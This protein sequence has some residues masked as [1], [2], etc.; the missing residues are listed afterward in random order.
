M[1]FGAVGDLVWRFGGQKCGS[2][3][4]RLDIHAVTCYLYAELPWNT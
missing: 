1:L 3:C 4:G 2:H